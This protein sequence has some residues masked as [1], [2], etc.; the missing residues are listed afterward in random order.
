MEII[1]FFFKALISF[2]CLLFFFLIMF[3]ILTPIGQSN[4]KIEK[5]KSTIKPIETKVIAIEVYS[6]L[7]AFEHLID[8][9]VALSKIEEIEP[10]YKIIKTEKRD[11]I[12]I[13]WI[14][15]EQTIEF[16][17]SSIIKLQRNVD[18]L[19]VKCVQ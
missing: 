16:P 14:R 13:N 4:D 10:N 5:P 1:K 19:F 18:S 12:K 11:N 6:K 2:I 8:Y 3:L 7:K 15:W 9:N 17:D